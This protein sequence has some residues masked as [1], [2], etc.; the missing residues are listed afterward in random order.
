MNKVKIITDS[1]CDLN[2]DMYEGLDVEVIPFFVNFNEES[3][4]DL[5]EMDSEKLFKKVEETNIHPKTAAASPGMFYET[6]K[7]YIDKGY[8]VLYLG[9]G[10]DLSGAF[11]IASTAALDLPENRVFLVDSQNLSSG[12]GLLLMKAVKF[13]DQGL[14]AKEIKEEVEKLVPRVRSQFVIDTLDYLHRGGRCSGTARIFGTLLKVHPLI[15]V[16]DG[17]MIVAKKPRGTLKKAVDT[18]LEYF[19]K[20]LEKV[21]PEC[22]FI[23]HVLSDENEEYIREQVSPLIPNANIIETKAG[24]VIG[25]H[26]GPKTIGILYIVNE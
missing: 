26:C 1:T 23:T 19:Y 2:L 16:V 5:I 9:I 21:D 8:D 11:Q 6:F 22:I 24:S 14:S 3:Y 25:S 12:S 10:S 15:R 20:D 13:R 7:K 4:L 18:M 17:E